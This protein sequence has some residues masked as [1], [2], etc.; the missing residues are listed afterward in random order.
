[1]SYRGQ[2]REM[3]YTLD[4]SSNQVH[5]TRLNLIKNVQDPVDVNWVRP[6]YNEVV[7]ELF[8]AAQPLAEGYSYSYEAYNPGEE[9]RRLTV[10]VVG[11]DRLPVAGGGS[12][13][14]WI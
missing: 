10:R 8:A 1:I 13:D 7:D 5:G 3:M 14:A 6:F 12:V 11:S 4:F 2:Q 9:P